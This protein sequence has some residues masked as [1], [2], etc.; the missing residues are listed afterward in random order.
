MTGS[1][2]Q[3]A[4]RVIQGGLNYTYYNLDMSGVASREGISISADSQGFKRT[5][6]GY[7]VL[8]YGMGEHKGEIIN[9]PFGA[10]KVLDA[11]PSPNTVDVAVAW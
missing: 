1:Q 6:D 9:T 11:C 8:A 5:P 2:F 7:I 4:G 10:G 3:S